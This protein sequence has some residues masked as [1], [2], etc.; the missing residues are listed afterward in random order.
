MHAFSSG[1]P[2]IGWLADWGSFAV[3]ATA[4]R[5]TARRSLENYRWGVRSVTRFLEGRGRSGWADVQGADMRAYVTDSIVRRG[6]ARSTVA[7]RQVGATRYLHHIGRHDLA[8]AMALSTPR[9]YTRYGRRPIVLSGTQAAALVDVP[10][11]S[12]SAIRDRA[13]LAILHATGMRAHELCGLSLLQALEMVD[14]GKV[15]IRGKGNK[16]REVLV[17]PRTREAVRIYCMAARSARHRLATSTPARRANQATLDSRV[18]LL[19]GDHGARLT[20]DGLRRIVARAGARI[21]EPALTPL[22]LR[23]TFA[24]LLYSGF[25]EYA[26]LETDTAFM[27]LG[28][29]M[30]HSRP[31]TTQIYVHVAHSDLDRATRRL[32]RG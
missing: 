22:D 1:E 21:G 3:H 5:G 28:R 7:G 8:D 31:D 32:Q 16:E 17:G 20:L 6:L 12:P 29:L 27:F 2:D 23:H 19:L 26:G 15:I 25:T 18:A 9:Y 14:R 4:I 30:G 10:G 11:D 24:T 13:A